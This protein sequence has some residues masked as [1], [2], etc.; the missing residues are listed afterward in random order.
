MCIRDRYSYDANSDQI[1]TWAM[2]SNATFLSIIGATGVVTGTPTNAYAELSFYANVTC[3]GLNGTAYENWTLSVWNSAPTITST[4]AT[5]GTQDSSY[6]YNANHDDEGV[7]GGNF[8][9]L[10]TNYTGSVSFTQATGLLSFTPDTTGVFWFNIT[11]DD[12]RDV[13]N[14][15]LIHI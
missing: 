5:T 4:P 13:A 14:L 11:A 12:Q 2:A 10:V 9:T 6:T 1:V 8:T 15:S 7:G 3:T